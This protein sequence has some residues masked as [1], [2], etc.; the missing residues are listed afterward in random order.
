MMYSLSLHVEIFDICSCRCPAHNNC[1]SKCGAELVLSELYR[2]MTM[3]N[4][5]NSNTPSN[6]PM[7][8]RQSVDD[9][10]VV[11]EVTPG[12]R[13][14]QLSLIRSTLKESSNILTY[15]FLYLCS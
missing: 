10:N 8:K 14:K 1:L 9:H 13:H 11:D 15:C 3:N 5:D 4:V 2:L 6:S 12:K 7:K